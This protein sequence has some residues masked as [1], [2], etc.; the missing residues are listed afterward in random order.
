MQSLAAHVWLTTT[1][2]PS[3]TPT[4]DPDSVTPGPEGF[5]VIALIVVAVF[6]LVAD[7]MRRIRRGRV[8]AD[9]N[10]ELDAEQARLAA[11]AEGLPSAVEAESSATDPESEP[12]PRS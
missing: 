10:D 7:M 5:F 4:L 11:E 3:P 9:V 2:T 12:P 8:R 6:L 1:V